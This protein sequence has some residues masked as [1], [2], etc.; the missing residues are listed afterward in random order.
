MFSRSWKLYIQQSKTSFE[1]MKLG[2]LKYKNIFIYHIYIHFEF[3]PFYVL[4]L[5]F[6][7]YAKFSLAHKLISFYKSVGC[8]IV[9]HSI[10]KPQLVRTGTSW[11]NTEDIRYF[12]FWSGQLGKD[13]GEP[14]S[15]K[16]CICRNYSV[17]R[18][19]G[20]LKNA[21]GRQHTLNSP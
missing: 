13:S 7:H 21:A 18:N 10:G 9:H 6:N 17:L 11:K 19:S 15:N 14:L 20:Y 16:K 3:L 1:K 5:Q 12:K 8:F 2:P 4:Y